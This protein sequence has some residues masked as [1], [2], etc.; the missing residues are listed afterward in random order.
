MKYAQIQNG[1]ILNLIVLNDTAILTDF[2]INPLD[3]SALDSIQRVDNL[4]PMPQMGWLFD[5]A[6]FSAPDWW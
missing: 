5:G 6:N 4:N 2:M 1:I 3:G